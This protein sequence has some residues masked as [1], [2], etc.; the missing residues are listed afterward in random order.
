MEKTPWQM[1]ARS[2]RRWLPS[3]FA[4][5]QRNDDD[6]LNPRHAQNSCT[7]ICNYVLCI[8]YYISDHGKPQVHLPLPI[9]Y[10]PLLLG[11]ACYHPKY[12]PLNC[13][14]AGTLQLEDPKKQKFFWEVIMNLSKIQ[15]HLTLIFVSW[16]IYLSIHLSDRSKYLCISTSRK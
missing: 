9:L 4:T 6:K 7:C 10:F 16:H 2:C 15:R 12:A 13:C 8:Q 1:W 5:N 3:S 11:D 14:E